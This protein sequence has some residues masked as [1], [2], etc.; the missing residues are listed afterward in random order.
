M[1]EL[2]QTGTK[3]KRLQLRMCHTQCWRISEFRHLY[4]IFPAWE[5]RMPD[6]T[7][8]DIGTPSKHEYDY[9]LQWQWHLNTRVSFENCYRRFHHLD[10]SLSGMHTLLLTA[11]C[12]RWNCVAHLYTLHAK[13]LCICDISKKFVARLYCS[14]W[15]AFS[16][17][18]T[19]KTVCWS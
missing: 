19:S 17:F 14:L 11:V 4:I 18:N 5:W 6:I 9:H 7:S 8:R 15:F 13:Y 3:T 12:L 10:F 16:H 2:M 1:G